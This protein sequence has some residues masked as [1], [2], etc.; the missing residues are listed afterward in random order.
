[1][2]KKL[3]SL[4][5]AAMMLLAVVPSAA[6]AR[7]A[8][9]PRP[10]AVI[11]TVEITGFTP[12]VWGEHPDCEVEVPS[13]AHYSITDTYWYIYYSNGVNG[14]LFPT[15]YF[16][17][18]NSTVSQVFNVTPEEG[19]TMANDVTVTING[20]PALVD[21]VAWRSDGYLY[22]TTVDYHMVEP[23]SDAPNVLHAANVS[24][25]PFPA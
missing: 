22:V 3:I 21:Y 16:N 2:A 11:D 20:D 1:M 13:G 10:A 12:P 6:F 23:G 24:S 5:V 4:F 25:S 15:E 19:Y 18:N 9:E 7:V 8:E 14:F 17:A